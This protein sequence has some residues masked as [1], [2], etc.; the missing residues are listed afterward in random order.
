MC[1]F[2]A[3][4]ALLDLRLLFMND[5]GKAREAEA[6]LSYPNCSTTYLQAYNCAGHT[7]IVRPG[8]GNE[9]TA[10]GNSSVHEGDRACGGA[11]KASSFAP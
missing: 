2:P 3:R 8:P 4:R 6:D 11:V 7:S 10:A 5:M 9:A 1:D